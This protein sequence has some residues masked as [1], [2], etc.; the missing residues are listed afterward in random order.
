MTPSQYPWEREALEHLRAALPDHEPYRA[1][2][3]FE[4]TADD[5]S[6]NEV[7]CLVLTPMGLFLVEVKSHRGAVSGDGGTWRWRF[8]G[9][10][11]SRDNPRLLANRKAK[12]LKARLERSQ[13]ARKQ[14]LPFVEA[15]VFLAATDLDAS[16]LDVAGRQ[17][18][19]VRRGDPDRPTPIPGLEPLH[20]W[21][22][23]SGP[24]LGTATARRLER[25]MDEIGIRRSQS[26]RQVGDYQLEELLEDRAG[27]QDWRARHRGLG[28]RRR[29]RIYHTRAAKGSE[30]RD[31]LVRAAKREVLLLQ[32]IDHPGI[33]KALDYTEHPLGPAVIFEAP[34]D[35]QRLDHWLDEHGD[36]LTVGQRLRLL[37]QLVETLHFAHG[38]RLVHRG[39]SPQSVLVTDPDGD[40][41]RLAVMDWHAGTRAPGSRVTG[42]SALRATLHPDRLLDDAAGAYVAPEVRTHP[43]PDGIKADVFSLGAVAYHLFAGQPP[44]ADA[45]EL[46]ERLLTDDALDL[47][48]AVDGVPRSLAWLVLDSTRPNPEQRFH[49]T[50][51]LLDLLDEIED[52]LTAPDEPEVDPERASKGDL[53]PGG[54]EI[55]SRLGQGSTAIVFLVRRH[56]HGDGREQV[57]KLARTPGKNPLLDDEA[58]VLDRL[59]HQGIVELYDAVRVGDHAGLL[60]ARAGKETLAKRLRVEGRLSLD[61]LERFGEDLLQ[62]VQWLEEK[63]ISHR[64]VKPEN[65]GIQAV[66]KND[67]LHLVLFDFSLARAPADRCDLGTPPYL[68]PFLRQPGRQRWDLAAERFA[69]AVT[70]YEMATGQLPSWGGGGGDPLYAKE[71]VT[72]DPEGFFPS[73]RQ[74]LTDF[75]RRALRRDAAERFD[76]AEQMLRAWRR[77]FLD[78]GRPTLPTPHPTGDG[79]AGGLEQVTLDTQV[80][81]LGLSSRAFHA[82]ERL[83]VEDVRAFLR[84]PLGQVSRM[85]GVGPKTRRELLDTVKALRPRFPDLAEAEATAETTAAATAT[86]GAD[87]EAEPAGEPTGD[88][89]APAPPQAVD[90]V[91]EVLIPR[92]RRGAA[93]DGGTSRER[94]LRRF[95]GLETAP[96]LPPRPNQSQV[97]RSLELTRERV[98]QLL[99]QARRRWAKTPAVT[100]VRDDVAHLLDARGGV[101]SEG[102]V[103]EALLATRGAR[104]T[105][106]ERR[107]AADAVARAASEVERDR[108]EP[109]WVLRRAGADA[110]VVLARVAEPGDEQPAQALAAWAGR[111]GQK[112]DELAALDPLPAPSAALARLLEVTPP[113]GAVP[114]PAPRLV[115]LAAACSATAAV[116]SRAELYPR[117]LPAARALVLAAGVAH[118]VRSLEAEEL[119]ERVRARY[120]ESEPLPGR[121]ELDRLLEEAGIDLEWRENE[122][123]QGEGR[124]VAPD[125][126]AVLSSTGTFSHVSRTPRA[127]P[128]PETVAAEEFE[129]RLRRAADRGGFLVLLA[130]PERAGHAAEAIADRFE[131]THLSLDRLFLDA[132]HAA[133]AAANVDWR[134]V[135]AADAADPG[136]RDWRNLQRLVERALPKVEERLLATPGTVLLT[137]PGLLGRYDRL[138]LFERLRE[139][140]TRPEEGRA[141][142]GLWVLVPSDEQ[143]EAPRLHGRAIPVLGSG[144]RG[145]VPESWVTGAHLAGTGG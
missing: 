137:E 6:I 50:Q 88:D 113:E 55:V 36:G 105:G 47:S 79:A 114:L 111:L 67:A 68:D 62:I 95:L 10:E 34:L 20:D 108:A 60:M 33:V 71:E 54:I 144:D 1:W 118:G 72:I 26:L 97:A 103:A 112:A 5:G 78:A 23:R 99:R 130:L 30:S 119:R 82:L 39:L 142:T 59:R 141:L 125:R 145:W 7:D 90:R 139:R 127:A 117:G 45:L 128:P 93:E 74:G 35:A 83:G 21:T 69:V 101:M 42:G 41:P 28:V 29:L 18:V 37:R 44:A 73:V 57:L 49:D 16:G 75:F 89:D 134:V 46:Q 58:E 8:E 51:D 120:P 124:Y 3:N 2:S 13:A 4:L 126:F 85:R 17:G 52:E 25:A 104:A 106:D 31:T 87:G 136:S 80:I 9:K 38:R 133:A 61:F 129:R 11:T 107:R 63:G 109:R 102:E 76:N 70:L 48:D 65:L 66:G 115:R 131:V 77:I 32:G 100:A 40:E 19:F 123:N 14:K 121:P 43:E 110:A 92:P 64:D 96:G 81:E 56:G 22:P 15:V 86:A 53:L 84:T 140:L 132:L 12:R 138:D 143:S 135:L 24:K 27:W 122:E 116:S 91:A 94:A 98:S